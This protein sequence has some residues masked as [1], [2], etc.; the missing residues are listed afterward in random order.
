MCVQPTVITAGEDGKN[1]MIDY[2]GRIIK[3]IDAGC[4]L[5]SVAVTPEAFGQAA[6]GYESKHYTHRLE[7]PQVSPFQ[8]RF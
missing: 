2:Q 4:P 3:S 6:G 1:K 8:D 7:H 5:F